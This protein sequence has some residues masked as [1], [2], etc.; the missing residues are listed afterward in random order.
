MGETKHS[1]DEQQDTFSYDDSP[2]EN[3]FTRRKYIALGLGGGTIVSLIILASIF[4][5]N[6]ELFSLIFVFYCTYMWV[7]PLI[8]ALLRNYKVSLHIKR[9]SKIGRIYMTIGIYFFF[10]WIVGLIGLISYLAGGNIVW[11]AQALFW[12]TTCVYAPFF[13][14]I[15]ITRL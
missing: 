2:S 10:L 9:E 1:K 12:G 7:L 6:L 8:F 3:K 11:V 13:L 15:L 14:F 4:S 5:E